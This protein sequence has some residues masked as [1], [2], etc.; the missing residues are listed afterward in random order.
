M[1]RPKNL[2]SSVFEE[3]KPKI[4]KKRTPPELSSR[5]FAVFKDLT[6]LR[7]DAFVIYSANKNTPRSTAYLD[8]VRHIDSALAI[9]SGNLLTPEELRLLTR[10]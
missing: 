8:V 2:H 6:K 1:K 7:T 5:Q 9:L 4:K 10:K 3:E